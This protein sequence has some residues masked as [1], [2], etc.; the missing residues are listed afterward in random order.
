MPSAASHLSHTTHMNRIANF[1]DE[2]QEPPELPNL[3]DY[4]VIAGEFGR[5]AVDA[6]QARRI[7]AVLDGWR[8]R[9]WIEFRDRAGSLFRVRVR[10]IRSIV[11][12]TVEQ[13][14]ADRRL[15]RA[16]KNEEKADRR[17]WDDD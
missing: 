8:L 5:I 6:D 15:E 3:G 4:F 17:S 13:R 10:H 2:R 12:S 16:Q 9:T 11:E 14:A 7:S 1:L